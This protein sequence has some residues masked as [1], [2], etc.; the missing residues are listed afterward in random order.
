MKLHPLV[1]E[2][3]QFRGV[4]SALVHCLLAAAPVAFI[5]ACGGTT[6]G[7][8]DNPQIAVKVDGKTVVEGTCTHFQP[9]DSEGGAGSQ[10]R[11]LTVTNAGS[12]GT[13]CLS[14]VTFTP[15]DANQMKIAWDTHKADAAKCP[16]GFASLEVGKSLKATVSYIPKPGLTASA[17]LKIEHNSKDQA[18]FGE[19]C[20]DI[21]DLGPKVRLDT[22]ELVWINPKASQPTEKCAY[23]G[24]DGTGTLVYDGSS[25]SP[26][27]PEYKIT[28]QPKKGESISPLGSTG[29][30]VA[31]RAKFAVCVAMTPDGNPDND[32][33]YLVIQTNDPAA[34]EV[35]SRLHTTYQSASKFTVQSQNADTTDLTFNFQGAPTGATRTIKVSNDGPAAWSWQNLPKIVA[36]EQ[37]RQ[38]DVDAAFKLSYKRDGKDVDPAT[39]MSA[40]SV[41]AGHVIDFVITYTAPTNG[42]AAPAATFQI[43]WKQVPNGGK[44]IIPVL[45]ATCDVPTLATSP[46]SIW[47]YAEKGGKATGKITY[48]NQSCAPLDVIKACVNRGNAT[49]SGATPCE[50]AQTLSAYTGLASGGGFLT[51]APSSAG[52]SNGLTAVDVEFHPADDNKINAEDVLQLVFCQSGTASNACDFAHKTVFVT[53]NTT[54][55]IQLPKVTLAVDTE[56]PKAAQPLSIS[57]ILTPGTYPDGKTWRWSIIDRPQG[58]RTWIYPDSETTV[59]PTIVILPDR[60]GKYT[61]QVQALTAD[62]TP[63]SSNIAWSVPVTID[64][65][66]P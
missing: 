53:G 28:Q 46:G 60:S 31:N 45:N 11:T 16:D 50:S 62:Q 18:A 7:I 5:A 2:T 3:S 27:N 52:T 49:T 36:D 10:V 19:T 15:T 38:A 58:S 32:E 12:Q 30:P 25:I 64:V 37:D 65:T 26:G 54:A 21:S 33:T 61:V 9:D 14:K 41:A 29:N 43:D 1:R 22:S 34:P 8:D 13:L 6:T 4:A 42:L 47:L 23:F 24:N 57:G 20:F 51:V 44:L 35:K 17:T 56:E 55:G 66:V 39:N 63:G 40:G 48:A 59:D